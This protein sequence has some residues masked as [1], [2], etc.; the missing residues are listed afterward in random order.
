MNKRGFTL[1]E[2]LA[3]IVILSLLTLIGST[4]VTKL[5]KNSKEKLY[6][7]QIELIKVAAESWG[8][9]NLDKLPVETGECKYITLKNLKTYGVLEDDIINPKT[10]KEFSDDMKIKITSTLTE[11]GNL[12]FQYEVDSI[13]VS[14]CNPTY[15]LCL[16]VSD[17]DNSNT[18]TP[19]DKYLCRV[20][21]VMEKGFENG[22]Y[23]YVL[24]YN[25]NDG[26]IIEDFENSTTLNL[27]MDRNICGDGTVSTADNTCLTAW[28]NQ[29]DYE[30]AA[31]MKLDEWIDNSY[32][33]PVTAMNHIYKATKDW[34]NVP[35]IV[36]NYNDNNYGGIKTFGELT[37]IINQN[38]EAVKVME[39]EKGY[40]NLKARLPLY[41]ELSTAGCEEWTEET[42]PIYL[43]GYLYNGEYQKYNSLI[44]LSGIYGYWSLDSSGTGSTWYVNYTGY[45]R[46]STVGYDKYN[47]VRPVITIPKLELG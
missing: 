41:A 37:Q 18:I 15:P 34:S 36:V 29:K 19:G 31:G 12:N 25:D 28:M 6:D 30:F 13:D 11:L 33:G 3:I 44:H 21:D 4:T 10:N 14:S 26:N 17:A 7:A 42:C 47:G 2:L 43:M 38:N 32:Y 46:T 16:L 1:V 27:I 45:L 22:Y 24:S 9:N 35:N 39:K 23:F 8:S 40:I 5:V 20:K